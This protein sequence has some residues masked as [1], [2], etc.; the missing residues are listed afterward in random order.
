MA[1]NNRISRIPKEAE[2][3]ELA[4][5]GTVFEDYRVTDLPPEELEIKELE[6]ELWR[7]REA[8]EKMLNENLQEVSGGE[9]T[10]R[11]LE[12]KL[13]A[14]EKELKL[15]YEGLSARYK[16]FEEMKK[17]LL[18]EL[19][20]SLQEKPGVEESEK[21]IKGYETQI[22]ELTKKLEVKEQELNEKLQALVDSEKKIEELSA[23]KGKLL[24]QTCTIE[25][26]ISKQISTLE[27]IIRR[28]KELQTREERLKVTIL[29]SKNRKNEEK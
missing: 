4:P 24:E 23:E 11:E 7:H 1:E 21:V 27:E 26:I 28:E 14:R 19:K 5:I 6:E 2:S 25:K 20:K 13:A 12:S 9:K 8:L 22:S 3:K 15:E 16:S 18:E 17:T 29:N 10:L